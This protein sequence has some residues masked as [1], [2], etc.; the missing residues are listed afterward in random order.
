MR[1]QFE[2]WLK[3]YKEYKSTK[4][5]NIIKRVDK[6]SD[7]A[8]RTQAI[9]NGLFHCKSFIEYAKKRSGVIRTLSL[10]PSEKNALDLL[11]DFFQVFD[12]RKTNYQIDTAPELQT[13]CSNIKILYSYKPVF[14]WAMLE[15]KAYDAPSSLDDICHRMIDF[16]SS[17]LEKGII[18]EK[19]DSI[20]SR[21]NY[22]Y[23][24]AKQVIKCNP[25]AVLQKDKVV[26]FDAKSQRVGFTSRYCP[27]ESEVTVIKQICV[28]KLD[29]YYEELSSSFQTS[30]SNSNNV[31]TYDQIIKAIDE[32]EALFTTINDSDKLKESRKYIYKLRLIWEKN[33]TSDYMT[34]PLDD[35]SEDVDN[36]PDGKIESTVIPELEIIKESDP[37]KIG[38]LVR[39]TMTNMEKYEFYFEDKLL[40]KMQNPVWSKA[41]LKLYFPFLKK[42]DLSNSLDMQIKDK[43]G[44]GRF[45]KQIFSFS[46][47]KYI[48]TSEWYKESKPYFIKWYNSLILGKN[49]ENKPDEK[50]EISKTKSPLPGSDRNLP[51]NKNSHVISITQVNL[52]GAVEGR[53]YLVSYIGKLRKVCKESTSHYFMPVIDSKNKEKLLPVSISNAQKTVFIINDSF[54]RYK[55]TLIDE[56]VLEIRKTYFT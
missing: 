39:E 49:E 32:L 2:I 5:S 36:N 17:R 41:T 46:G 12:Y 30:C 9:E 38:K 56:E 44:N 15:L 55:D 51:P 48:I 3:N 29:D 23:T 16:Y 53:Y 42:Y 31:D 18:A 37:R 25:L 6:I 1:K 11:G 35:S 28:K 22:D 54:Q 40:E 13:Y 8:I 52:K 33:T 19:A 27:N 14:I 47:E 34:Q 21:E 20:F 26:Y 50:I 45:W 10:N 24:K 43:K 7:D 4:V